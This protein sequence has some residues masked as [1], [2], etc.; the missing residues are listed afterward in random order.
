MAD[1]EKPQ[2]PGPPEPEDSTEN[3]HIPGSEGLVD[4]SKK[5]GTGKGPVG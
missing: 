5:E 3:K 1:M 2:R 4:S